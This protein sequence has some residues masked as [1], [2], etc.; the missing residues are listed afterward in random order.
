MKNINELMLFTFSSSN[1]RASV[2]PKS[3]KPCV[4]ITSCVQEANNLPLRSRLL[5]E[6]YFP[7]E[8]R[9][10]LTSLTNGVSISSKMSVSSSA[11]NN[12]FYE[13]LVDSWS[14]LYL[15]FFLFTIISFFVNHYLFYF[16]LSLTLLTKLFGVF[17]GY[18]KFFSQK[19]LYVPIEELQD[20]YVGED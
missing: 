4:A 19:D 11:G 2:S 20:Y 16:V 17:L 15:G 3:K 18:K 12:S 8:D 14:Y 13:L 10:E 6:D 9:P 7:A 1:P 5:L